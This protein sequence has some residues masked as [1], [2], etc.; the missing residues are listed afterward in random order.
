MQPIISIIPD[1]CK[2]E[3][4]IVQCVRTGQ[5]TREDSTRSAPSLLYPVAA[6][7]CSQVSDLADPALCLSI[8]STPKSICSVIH[9]C[10]VSLFAPS[11]RVLC[12]VNRRVLMFHSS[13]VGGG[14]TV[15]ETLL[16]SLLPFCSCGRTI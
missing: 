6:L 15:C 8:S 7:S 14:V 2:N 1:V 4:T 11:V 16:H 13:W 12:W 3:P 10:P 9:H 5:V